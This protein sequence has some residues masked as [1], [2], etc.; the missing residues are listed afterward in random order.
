MLIG[1]LLLW[2]VT[3]VGLMIVTMIVPGVSAK[4]TGDLLLAALIL[5]VINALIR[6][7]L[8]LLTWPLTVLSFGLFALLINAFMIQLTSLLV[9]GFEVKDFANALLAAV[10]MAFLAILGFIVLEWWLLDGVFW[11]SVGP[12]RSSVF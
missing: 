4:S 2:L 3:A 10:V 12:V 7:L 1:F 6:P 11:V 9:P 5:G 8:L